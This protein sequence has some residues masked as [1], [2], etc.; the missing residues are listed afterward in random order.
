MKF[1]N[2]KKNRLE[3]NV[4]LASY[5]TQKVNSIKNLGKPKYCYYTLQLV[6]LI[7]FAYYL[8]GLGSVNVCQRI[9][10]YVVSIE[11]RIKI[12]LSFSQAEGG[13]LREQKVWGAGRERGDS[14]MK[15]LPSREH[16]R[17]P[18]GG[19]GKS[20]GGSYWGSPPDIFCRSPATP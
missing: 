6:I 15:V 17:G 3:K 20:V 11:E 7:L 16:L 9:Y 12:L 8:S 1:G 4:F 19:S 18:R 14:S 2:K 10:I 5:V 13:S